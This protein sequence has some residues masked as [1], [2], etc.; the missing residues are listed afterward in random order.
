MRG[1][2]SFDVVVVGGG[3]AG[4]AAAITA[5][6]AGLSVAVLEGAPADRARPG[7]TLHPGAEV[8]LR[9]LGLAG[10]VAAR[11]WLRHAGHWV[12]WGGPR[13]FDAFGS[14]AAG[15]WRGYQAPRPE[16]DALFLARAAEAGATV[17]RGW[18]AVRPT[19]T[20][21]R[22]DGV[23]TGAGRLAAGHVVDASGRRHWSAR[24][25]G[26]PV[27][28][29]SRP[30]VASWGHLTGR[31]AERDDAPLL[32]ADRTGWT[33]TA[34]VGPDT[35]A[36]VGVAVTGADRLRAAPLRPEGVAAAG[37]PA[38][39][40]VTWRCVAL[41]AA[42]GL[43]L[44]GDAAAVLDPASGSGILR[45]LVTGTVAARA[46]V[47]LRA[48]R[49]PETQVVSAYRRWVV[50]WFRADVTRLDRL[51]RVFPGWTG[52]G[53]RPAALTPRRAGAPAGGR[54]AGPGR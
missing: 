30:L 54:P 44:A 49:V 52:V 4:A 53:L 20:A 11:G 15:P 31:W 40:D 27:H 10:A 19:V 24:R 46:A 51:Y 29:V 5:A 45:A 42:P 6:T 36:W 33:W 47:D 14:D 38:G 32:S 43:L 16:L 25:L 34:R 13:R 41:S 35:Y 8:V 37:D 3:P 21:G 17:L 48:G 23:L 28:R 12:E 50:D 18:R 39:V 22:V 7:E 9:E 2:T 26:L 1:P